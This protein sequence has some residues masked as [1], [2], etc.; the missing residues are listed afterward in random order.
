MAADSAFAGFVTNPD[1]A[2]LDMFEAA[3]GDTQ[4]VE[5]IRF[6]R[7]FPEGSLLSEG[8]RAIPPTAQGDLEPDPRAEVEIALML[9]EARA[10]A[11][12][13]PLTWSSALAEVAETY[14]HE[15][16]TGGFFSHDSP[17]TGNV[18]DRLRTAGIRFRVAGE[19]LGLA[20]TV[21]RAHD[22]WMN[23]TPHRSNMLAPNY[24]RVGVGVV[25]TPL[26]LIAVQVFQG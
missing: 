26:G 21:E 3:S 4:L 9:N 6:N 13:A 12:L 25:R 20:P 19:N 24:T 18:G 8:F 5:V 16:A 17:T 22:G 11:G 1:G 15:M 14:A 7:R 23:S 2:P 10:D